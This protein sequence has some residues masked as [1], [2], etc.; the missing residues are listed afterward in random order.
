MHSMERDSDR[1]ERVGRGY[2]R[3]HATII[4]RN[5]RRW[6]LVERYEVAIMRHPHDRIVITSLPLTIF[7]KAGRVAIV[8]TSAAR[9]YGAPMRT[10]PVFRG[11]WH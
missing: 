1:T 2:Q 10:P 5:P 11:W 3:P 9:Q 6:L 7:E 8:V 4:M